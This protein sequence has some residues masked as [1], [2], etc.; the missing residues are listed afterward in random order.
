[1]PDPKV[2]A[3]MSTGRL[4]FT[5]NFNC[6]LV[7]LSKAG[8]SLDVRNGLFWEQHIQNGIRDRLKD[9]FDYIFVLD[10]DTLFSSEDVSRLLKLI[11]ERQEADALCSVQIR[12]QHNSV[13]LRELGEET[14]GIK[15]ADYSGELTQIQLGHFGLTVF[16]AERFKDF[17]MPWF[18][19]VPSNSGQWDDHRQDAD[20][21]FWHKWNQ[22]GRTL[23]QA[24]KVRVGHMQLMVTWPGKDF[25]P[26]HQYMNDYRFGGPPTEVL[27]QCK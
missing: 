7:A 16:R 10:Y 8:V 17:P 15:K 24:N 12:R 27:E 11:I 5:D 22:Y 4:G 1:M 13:L 6:A 23:Y 25:Q 3:I 2:I 21:F 18:L 14:G 20:I 26:V 9:G 19:A